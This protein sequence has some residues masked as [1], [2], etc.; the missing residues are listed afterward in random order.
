MK[1]INLSL[2]PNAEQFIQEFSCGEVVNS[3]LVH[4]RSQEAVEGGLYCPDIFGNMDENSKSRF[5]HI[6][7]YTPIIHPYFY[8]EESPYLSLLL[9][10]PNA[11][12]KKVIYHRSYI[13]IEPGSSHLFKHQVITEE[14]YN[15]MIP[16]LPADAVI[17]TGTQAIE[18]LLK[19][20]DLHTLKHKTETYIE[21]HP[22]DTTAINRLKVLEQYITSNADLLCCILRFLPVT[23]IGLRPLISVGGGISPTTDFYRRIVNRNIRG[24]KLEK[25][26]APSIVLNNEKILFQQAVEGLILKH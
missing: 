1:K 7:L 15:K 20:V 17:Q 14:K 6:L 23:P 25:V 2:I 24:A 8:Q 16:T 22:A 13:V 18:S 9:D 12:I 5:G 10:M 3:D 4:Y 21:K 19:S 26:A 11:S